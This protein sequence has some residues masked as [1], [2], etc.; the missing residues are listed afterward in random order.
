MKSRIILNHSLF[1]IKGALLHD[2]GKIQIPIELLTKETELSKGEWA[3]LMQHPKLG[4][5]MAGDDFNNHVLSCIYY[6][7]EKFDGT[8]Y[9]FGLTIEIPKEAS[10]ITICDMYDAM[11]TSREYHAAM[12]HEA[13]M[14]QLYADAK[15][16]KLDSSI[17]D[18]LAGHHKVREP[19]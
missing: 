6:H 14:E 16:Y 3:M 5:Q 2:I 13:T 17:L 9:P 19:R 11:T 4:Y 10:I 18:V 15:N 12:T 1:F 7:H 8:G